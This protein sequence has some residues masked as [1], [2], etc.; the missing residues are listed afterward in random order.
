MFSVVN[1]LIELNI[2]APPRIGDLAKGSSA[3]S[4]RHNKFAT[5]EYN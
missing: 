3:S 4:Q 1:T 2:A 5:F